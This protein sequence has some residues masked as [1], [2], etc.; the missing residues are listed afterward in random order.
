MITPSPFLTLDCSCKETL[1]WLKK[2]LA[3]VPLRV[4]Q[5]FDLHDARQAFEGCACPH[6]GTAQCDCQ[7]V[8]LL[9]YDSAPEPATLILHGNEKKT[10]ISLADRLSQP[11]NVNLVMSIERALGV[12]KASF[13]N[14]AP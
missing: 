12:K 10:W 8:I 7:M 3:A 13:I 9:V 14:C 1:D 4:M 11:A 2:R 5:T 6:H